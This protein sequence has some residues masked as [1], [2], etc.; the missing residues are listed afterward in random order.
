MFTLVKQLSSFGEKR[1]LDIFEAFL[2]RATAHF[3][4]TD[5]KLDQI[6]QQL[7]GLGAVVTRLFQLEADVRALT[8][9]IAK[10]TNPASEE[11]LAKLHEQTERVNAIL[12]DSP[13]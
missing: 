6:I 10:L 7:G 9:E 4:T 2:K 8:A 11:A 12:P 1:A 3:L 5:V 13:A